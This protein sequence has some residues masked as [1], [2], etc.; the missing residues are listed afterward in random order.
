MSDYFD[1]SRITELQDLLGADTEAILASMLTSMT[2]AIERLETAMAAGE[3]AGAVDAA[4]RARND[5]LMLSADSLQGA[6]TEL[7]DAARRGDSPAADAAL[8]RV[9]RIWPPTRDGLAAAA[10]RQSSINP[11]NGDQAGASG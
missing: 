5:A 4:H 11:A 1:A 8:A 6:L 9:R 3:L 10:A 2:R 7:E